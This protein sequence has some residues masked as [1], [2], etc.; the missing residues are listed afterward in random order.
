M[1]KTLFYASSLALLLV[2][3]PIA[4]R[5]SAGYS[6]TAQHPIDPAC[7]EVCRQLLFECLS[8]AQTN[9]EERRCIAVYRRC[10]AHCK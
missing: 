3:S 1:K 7:V 6:S 10:T 2:L 8:G 9:G 4:T 5:Q